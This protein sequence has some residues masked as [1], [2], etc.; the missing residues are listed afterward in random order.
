MS[1]KIII[2]FASEPVVGVGFLYTIQV[3]GLDLVYPNGLSSVNIQYQAVG[4]TDPAKVEKQ[5]NLG[6]TINATLAFL[7]ANYSTTGITY[8]RVNDTI[9]VSTNIDAEVVVYIGALNANISITTTDISNI[10]TV[11]L[12]Y[13]FQYKNDVNDTYLCEIFKKDYTG[14]FEEIH[15]IAIL[16]KASV[17]N[18]LDPIRGGGLQLQLEASKGLTL[19]DLYSDDE[20]TF[21]VKLY[22]N[23]KLVFVG[24]MNPDGVYQD[25]VRDEWKITVDCVDGLGAISN[26]AFVQENGL[27]FTGK[28]RAIDIIYNCLKRTGTLMNI[29]TSINIEYDGLPEGY[30]ILESIYLNA[31]R[32]V[33]TDNETIM[34]CEDVLKSILDIFKACITQI[35]AEWYIY[36]PN[37]IFVEPYVVFNRFNINNVFIGNKTVNLNKELGSHADNFYPH[38]CGGNQRIEI[39]GALGGFRLGY[40]YG[41]VS[42]LLPNPRL[43]K[44]G[45]TL[46]YDGWDVL[47]TSL[48]INDPLKDSGFYFKNTATMSDTTPK[49]QSQ[50][51]FVTTDDLISLKLE[52]EVASD[53][54][55]S[56]TKFQIKQGIYYLSYFAEDALAP[57]DDAVNAVWTTDSSKFFTIYLHNKKGVFTIPMP[58]IIA[59]GNLTIG[60]VANQNAGTNSTTLYKSIDI[61]PTQSATAIEGEFH[62][63]ERANGT[64]TIV[65]PN[66]TVYNGDNPGV[67]YLGAVLDINQLPTSLWNR[68]NSLDKFP[69]LR[70][71]AEEEL[72]IAQKPMKIFRGDFFGYISYLSFIHIN[73]V[74]YFMPIEWSYNTFT[75]I[76]T[77]KQ[78]ELFVSE[79]NDVVYTYSIDYGETVKPTIK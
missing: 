59:D 51:L 34:S 29:N 14:I 11:A 56:F 75:N 3:D 38:H 69:L 58:K 48:L 4:G 66:Q 8:Q 42:G 35:D 76:T 33:R 2:S 43:V 19:E 60:I 79:I 39:R 77:C 32:F 67:L 55:S 13:F 37:E 46:N 31:D 36:K 7:V 22:K 1:K 73:N 9:E 63:V 72:R 78:L 17:T 64:S 74:G 68:R 61:V 54:G 5:G 27:H 23:K 57:I 53:F 40:K 25:Y 52:F 70:I 12:K 30:T 15:G 45:M 50:T 20:Q 71:A 21:S 62:T 16:E 10:S 18:H 44:T 28:M 41:F 65:K 47:S 6:L 49:V 24:Y 26:L